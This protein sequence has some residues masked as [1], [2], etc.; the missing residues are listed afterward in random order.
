[1]QANTSTANP[2][3]LNDCSEFQIE[4]FDVLINSMIELKDNNNFKIL[5]GCCGTDHRHIEELAKR[6]I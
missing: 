5:G 6:A 3:N 1:M 2:E 4:D